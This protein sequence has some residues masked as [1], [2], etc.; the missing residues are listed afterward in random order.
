[1][2]GFEMV[3]E[4]MLSEIGQKISHGPLHHAFIAPTTKLSIRI[5]EVNNKVHY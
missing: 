4:L 5:L 3:P 1:M 2:L